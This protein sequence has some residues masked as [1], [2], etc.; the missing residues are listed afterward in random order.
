[1]FDLT[2]V[3]ILRSIGRGNVPHA[4]SEL[5][6]LFVDESVRN[7]F[8][9]EANSHIAVRFYMKVISRDFSLSSLKNDRVSV[10]MYSSFDDNHHAAMFKFMFSDVILQIQ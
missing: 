1:M 9:D 2:G 6:W 8:E 7:W 4:A 10:K 3:K 5:T